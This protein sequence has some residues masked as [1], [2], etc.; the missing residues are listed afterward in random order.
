MDDDDDDDNDDDD[1]DDDDS[2]S[3]G[4]GSGGG[5]GDGGGEEEGEFEEEDNQAVPSATLSRSDKLPTVPLYQGAPISVKASW[6]AANYFAVSNNLSDSATKQLLDL[7]AILCPETNL[8]AKSTF[9][10]RNKLKC[11]E[12]DIFMYCSKCMNKIVKSN[13]CV[14]F[15]CK[16]VKAKVCYLAVLPFEQHLCTIFTGK[17]INVR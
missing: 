10:L 8:F 11:D 4:G 3:D 14:N 17:T 13:N 15:E 6:L 5:S 2:G 9:Q 12:T 7:I 16:K 1:D